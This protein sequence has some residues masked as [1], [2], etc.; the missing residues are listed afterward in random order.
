[1]LFPTSLRL[2][3]QLGRRRAYRDTGLRLCEEEREASQPKASKQASNLCSQTRAP[4][5]NPPPDGT[6]RD[7]TRRTTSNLAGVPLRE[8]VPVGLGSKT[9]ISF[10]GYFITDHFRKTAEASTVWRNPAFYSNVRRNP[11]FDSV[12]STSSSARH[13]ETRHS[14]L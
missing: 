14:I 9:L 3:R 2:G 13:R 7:E 6:R 8:R 4:L 5:F 1:M 11:A 12:N 10:W